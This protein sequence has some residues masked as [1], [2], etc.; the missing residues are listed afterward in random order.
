MP[1]PWNNCGV[2]AANVQRARRGF[3]A[4]VS[5]DYEAL[6]EF[7]DPAVQW[8]GGDPT[9]EGAC[10]NSDDVLKFIRLAREQ[11]GVGELVDVIDCGD[12]VVVVMRPPGEGELR[13]NLTTFRD[14]KAVEMV[15]FFSPEAAL[16]AT[17]A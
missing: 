17:A 9:A 15:A 10:H 5:G 2:S 6:R 12:Q 7:L 8:H 3:D 16:A 14:G 13:A 4:V 11:G 1:T